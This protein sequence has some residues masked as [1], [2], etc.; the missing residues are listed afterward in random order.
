MNTEFKLIG[1]LSK[2]PITN[3]NGNAV[4]LNIGCEE[5]VKMKDGT[6]EKN[7]HYLDVTAFGYVKEKALALKKGDQLICTGQI[8]TY[9][10][11]NKSSMTLNARAIYR[12]L[13][14][15]EFSDQ[16]VNR[17]FDHF[18]PGY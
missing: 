18:D 8:K 11:E 17:L 16:N 7:I 5:S 4:F 14:P 12:V 15:S 6:F 3:Q 1:F 13:K 10:K 2:D 9:K